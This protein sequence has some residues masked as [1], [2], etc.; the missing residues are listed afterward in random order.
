MTVVMHVGHA[1]L[2][3][4][5]APRALALLPPFTTG[6]EARGAGTGPGLQVQSYQDLVQEGKVVGRSP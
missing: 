4:W 6:R 2:L 1:P 3:F 5:P